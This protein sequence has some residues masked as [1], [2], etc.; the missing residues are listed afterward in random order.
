MKLFTI[1]SALAGATL[2][3]PVAPIAS[4]STS[5]SSSL[6]GPSTSRTA[7]E[8]KLKFELSEFIFRE[9]QHAPG[10]VSIAH[11]ELSVG[12][13]STTCAESG[14]P[15]YLAGK[16]TKDPRKFEKILESP[17]LSA[18]FLVTPKSGKPGVSCKD[19]RV[20]FAVSG[21]G[22]QKEIRISF[23]QPGAGLYTAKIPFPSSAPTKCKSSTVQHSNKPGTKVLNFHK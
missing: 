13:V 4:G 5:G 18:E 12:K 23:K 9:N 3:V 2:A 10:G 1:V 22:S 14:V 8:G 11:V 21:V 15:P 17:E 6:T 16:E 19:E 7:I 20:V